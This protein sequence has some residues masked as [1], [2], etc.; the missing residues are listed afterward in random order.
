MPRFALA[1]AA[2]NQAPPAVTLAGTARTPDFKRAISIEGDG[3][4][5]LAAKA[6]FGDTEGLVLRFLNLKATAATVRISILDKHLANAS[7]VLLTELA[8]TPLP[9]DR[10]VITLVISSFELKT[11]RLERTEI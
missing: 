3:V 4:E 2:L 5:L 1:A 7:E 11:I 6:P 8:G 10:G 9:I